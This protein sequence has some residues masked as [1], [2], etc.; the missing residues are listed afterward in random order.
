MYCSGYKP[1][2]CVELEY[3]W[4]SW[5]TFFPWG[6]RP[7]YVLFQKYQVRMALKE[8]RRRLYGRQAIMSQL[9]IRS[10]LPTA[11]GQWGICQM[12]RREMCNS[13]PLMICGN[14]ARRW[15]PDFFIVTSW[16]VAS[17]HPRKQWVR[18]TQS[19][20]PRKQWARIPQIFRGNLFVAITC[21]RF[22]ETERDTD[23]LSKMKETWLSIENDRDGI[24]V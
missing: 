9:G 13:R 19:C 1:G 16:G 18:I 20:H 6:V 8:C 14:C 22:K 5:S 21:T 7:C 24:F 3:D 4:P 12:R 23:F 17:R 15:L 2:W 11:P 10:H